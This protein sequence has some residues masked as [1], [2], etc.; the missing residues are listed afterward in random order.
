MN[1]AVYTR[2]LI[3]K[4]FYSFDVILGLNK[5]NFAILCFHSFS[6]D[7]DRYSISPKH[8]E[9][10][11]QEIG[12]HSNFVGIDYIDRVMKG[13]KIKGSNIMITIDDGYEDV[14]NI[15]KITNKYKIPV[16]LFVLSN[17]THANIEELGNSKKKL[18]W[19]QIKYLARQGWVIGSHSVTHPNFKKINFIKIKN[20]IILSK[21]TIEKKTG[22]IINSFAYPKGVYNG[23]ILDLLKNSEYKYAFSID[24]DTVTNK[25]S[26]FNLPRTIVDKTHDISEIVS[27]YSF[28]WLKFRKYTN[29]LG[30]WE[31]FI[32]EK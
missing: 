8:F 32:N 4:I 16:T 2:M 28:S 12:K 1:K 24:S 11:V 30:L 23:E 27:T 25:S 19:T 9:Q 10:I 18:S 21:N 26:K 20:E 14:I 29:K 22:K 31:R 3:K 15:L 6:I 5:N 13:E 17:P 7:N